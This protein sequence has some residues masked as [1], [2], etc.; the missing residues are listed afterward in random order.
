MT[1]SLGGK[2]F[3]T[4][5]WASCF[6]INQTALQNSKHFA[7]FQASAAVYLRFS[8]LRNIDRLWFVV[9]YGRVATIYR[10]RLQ[11]PSRLLGLLNHWWWD[12]CPEKSVTNYRPTL[13]NIPEQRRLPKRILSRLANF[14]ACSYEVICYAYIDTV[15]YIIGWLLPGAHDK[16]FRSSVATIFHRVIFLM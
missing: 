6:V 2:K 4:Q 10:S 3:S 7:R 14:T 13:G 15:Q 9:V 8:F 11:G 16:I 5:F 1:T 12:R